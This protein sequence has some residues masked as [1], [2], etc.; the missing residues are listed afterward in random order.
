MNIPNV[1][2]HTIAGELELPVENVTMDGNSSNLERW[3]SLGQLRIIMALERECNV[4]FRTLEISELRSVRA[5]CDRIEQL[6]RH[7]GGHA[8]R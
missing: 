1:V 7:Q 3:D 8:D 5:L 2:C 4:K 6:L